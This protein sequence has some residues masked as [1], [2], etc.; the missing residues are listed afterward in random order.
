MEDAKPNLLILSHVASLDVSK[1]TVF[2]MRYCTNSRALVYQWCLHSLIKPRSEHSKIPSAAEP[3][4][5]GAAAFVTLPKE[6]SFPTL[7]PNK[8]GLRISLSRHL[9]F[10]KHRASDTSRV[11]RVEGYRRQYPRSEG[12]SGS[13]S[14]RHLEES[15][16]MMG[17]YPER[18][19][20][21]KAKCKKKDRYGSLF[22]FVVL[23][24]P[25]LQVDRVVETGRWL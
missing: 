14:R 23:R 17:D 2:H 24:I 21:W 1:D 19:K 13:T 9:L 3:G 22:V 11:W 12:Y 25:L 5:A 10:R 7:R 15:E 8:L 6:S 18:R 20:K 4:L 16:A